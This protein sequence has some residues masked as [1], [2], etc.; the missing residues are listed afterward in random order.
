MNRLSPPQ[1]RVML[2]YLGVPLRKQSNIA[3]ERKVL[4]DAIKNSEPD[5]YKEAYDIIVLHKLPDPGVSQQIVANS[6]SEIIDDLVQLGGEKAAEVF[7][8]EA[9]N[10]ITN[11]EHK[12]SKLIDEFVL[13]TNKAIEEESKK[14][15]KI[16]FSVRVNE[17]ELNKLDFTP[18]RIF[19]DLL[20]LAAQRKNIMM[21]GPAG[22]GKTFIAGKVAESFNMDF[23]SQSCSAGMSESAFVGWLLP[24]GENGK[25]EY[26]SSEFV[27]I[28]ENGGVFLL[29]EIDAADPNVMIFINQALANDGFHIPQR[30]KKP[31]VK[32]HKDFVA[33]AA[34]NT[35]GNGADMQYVGR[36]QLDAATLDR[37]RVGMIAMDYDE[38]VESK[39][40]HNDVL[41]WGYRIR[42]QITKNH[43]K[44]I[45]STRLL[46][47]ATEMHVNQGWSIDKIA[48]NYFS[49]WSEEEKRM[50]ML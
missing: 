12:Y 32:K 18:P 47:D 31:Y 16:E 9:R 42:S 37:F 11:I 40:I 24:T 27:R 25:F 50:I 7:K 41:N 1:I 43:L 4:I 17:D 39:L 20:Q 28:Y 3:S 26:V 46:I 13:K 23:A 8:G 30:Y 44:R 36:N 33:I 48:N 2:D 21:V 38:T 35:Y 15:Q 14:F 49:D 5:R 29:D 34:A 6:I 19:K 10:Q 45:L 22:C